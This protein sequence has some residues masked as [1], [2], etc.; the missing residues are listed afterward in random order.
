M[1]LEMSYAHLDQHVFIKLSLELKD[2]GLGDPGPLTMECLYSRQHSTAGQPQDRKWINVVLQGAEM[3]E[4][5][6]CGT[7]CILP[8]WLAQL[9]LHLSVRQYSGCRK[10]TKPLP[11]GADSKMQ[12]L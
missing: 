1:L 5:I 8:C 11:V 9:F 10:Q 2:Q 3:L 4:F 12:C 7:V 6:I